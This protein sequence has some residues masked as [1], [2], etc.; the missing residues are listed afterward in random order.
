MMGL[1]KLMIF[2]KHNKELFSNQNEDEV[3]IAYR[4]EYQEGDYIKLIS[5][6]KDIYIKLRLDDSLEESIVYLND[7]E[8]SFSIPF[9]DFKKPYG[10]KAFT[11]ERHW[12]YVSILNE[13]EYD[14]YRNLALNTFDNFDNKSIYPHTVTNVVTANPQFFARNAIDGIFETSNH[15]SWPHSSWG[16]NSRKMH[17]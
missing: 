5:D 10:S 4:G 7:Y 1:F 9:G 2:N 16:I 8:Y 11:G 6:T 13:K 15:G 3:S 17:G 14:N 12:G